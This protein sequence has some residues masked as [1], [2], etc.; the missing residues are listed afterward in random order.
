[1]KCQVLG[2]V[3]FCLITAALPVFSQQGAAS[4]AAAEV[5]AGVG[6][7]RVG[8][9]P[10][11]EHHFE[12]ALKIDPGLAEV[13]ANLGLAFYAD[14]R[15]QQ[16]I[17]EFRQALKQNPSLQ[18]AR[19][20]L[21]LSLAAIGDCGQAIT[22]LSSE[23]DSTANTKLRRVAGLSLLNCRMQT[24]DNIGATETAAKLLAGYPD[25]PDVLYTTGQL[26]TKLSNLVY[27]RLT[28]VAPHSARSYQLMASVAA[29]DG[30]WKGAINA[31]RRALQID[32]SLEGVHLQIA[33]LLLTHSEQPGAW[34]DAMVELRDEL[35]IDPTSAEANYE[36]GEA[37][38]KHNQLNQAVAAL[39]RSLQLDPSAVPARIALAKALRS[40]GKDREA[41][42]SLEPAQKTAPDDPDIH[43][44]LAQLYRELGR[45]AEAR[46][47][48]Q[49]F[50]H[51]QKAGG[52]QT[53]NPEQ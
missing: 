19:S 25:D 17:P 23:F 33:I 1:M 44:L 28:K 12:S 50:E 11:A 29:A 47:Q 2:C 16:A 36:I 13:R 14:H 48:L 35:R 21:P 51:L 24:G 6:A 9:F 27:L 18:T 40:L 30:N 20:F 45:T 15:Y 4:G 43:F 52:T 53:P 37:Y 26:Y 10:A 49:A 22:G 32:P 46:T 5:E 41:L 31:Y 8:N 3:L 39:S 7:L 38:R 34:Q 42:L